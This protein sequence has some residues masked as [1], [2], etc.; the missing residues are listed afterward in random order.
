MRGSL[1]SFGR[2]AIA[3]DVYMSFDSYA[4]GQRQFYRA[5]SGRL[6]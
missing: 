2:V 3:V 5:L 4:D 6:G 1:C